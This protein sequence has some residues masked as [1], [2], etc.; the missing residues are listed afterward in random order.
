[1]CLC[2]CTHIHI[3]TLSIFISISDKYS[4]NTKSTTL[5]I[6]IP[7]YGAHY[8]FLFLYLELPSL[9]RGNL[10]PFVSSDTN[11]SLTSPL[12]VNRYPICAAIPLPLRM[13]S[14]S[15]WAKIPYDRLAHT[16]G[17]TS[18]PTWTDAGLLLGTVTPLSLWGL[19]QLMLSHMGSL[20]NSLGLWCFLVHHQPSLYPT[21]GCLLTLLR[22][23]LVLCW[24]GTT[25]LLCVNA[26][27]V[28]SQLVSLKINWETEG[29]EK[30]SDCFLLTHL[31][32]L[33]LLKTNYKYILRNSSEMMGFLYFA[34]FHCKVQILPK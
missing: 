24:S 7:H 10:V 33:T 9:T 23:H 25:L 27:L 34:F 19:S 31:F 16:P 6:P 22:F 29:K 3:C 8:S 4:E 15:T 30:D 14:H 18:H 11:T 28:L 21:C 26:Y 1:M 17:H 13:P 32:A 5:P 2:V 12:Y 20:L